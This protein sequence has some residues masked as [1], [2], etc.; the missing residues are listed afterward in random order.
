MKFDEQPAEPR[1]ESLTT[2]LL[3]VTADGPQV[4]TTAVTADGSQVLT[5]VSGDRSEVVAG[6]NPEV[7]TVAGLGLEQEPERALLPARVEVGRPTA[8][9]E[10]EWEH[11]V[12]DSQR[13]AGA[14]SASEWEHGVRFLDFGSAASPR[15]ASEPLEVSSFERELQL[16]AQEIITRRSAG[17]NSIKSSPLDETYP[18]ATNREQ[19]DEPSLDFAS[20]L[21][22]DPLSARP[23]SPA[24]AAPEMRESLQLLPSTII[25]PFP[26]R[27]RSRRGCPRSANRR[28]SRPLPQCATRTQLP[29]AGGVGARALPQPEDPRC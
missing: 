25:S 14:D 20:S 6:V 17:Q 11:G 23:R 4:L 22:D 28:N 2:A 19:F 24:E 13:P 9:F 18:A 3:V 10:S 1:Q 12:H 21:L 8:D 7:A 16:A 26:H 5:T 27:R 15:E 29:V